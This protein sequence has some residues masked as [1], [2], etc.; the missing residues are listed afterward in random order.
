MAVEPNPL[1]LEG[2]VLEDMS[3]T[4]RDGMLATGLV[5]LSCCPW[6]QPFTLST[7]NRSKRHPLKAWR[8]S[9]N[10]KR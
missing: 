1:D 8:P 5:L 10:S 6:F 9:G 3:P 7:V 2:P 4:G